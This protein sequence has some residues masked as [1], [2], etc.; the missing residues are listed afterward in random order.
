MS[1]SEGEDG[2]VEEVRKVQKPLAKRKRAVIVVD[3]D[4]VHPVPQAPAPLSDDKSPAEL[5]PPKGMLE[6]YKWRLCE[7]FFLIFRCTIKWFV[8]QNRFRPGINL[9]PHL[10]SNISLSLMSKRRLG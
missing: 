9:V 2:D 10:C 1:Q 6:W 3:E 5:E 4:E 8:K 7:S